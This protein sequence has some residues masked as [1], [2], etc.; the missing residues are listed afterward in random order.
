M[1]D[2]RTTQTQAGNVA[3]PGAP[4]GVPLLKFQAP[5]VSTYSNAFRAYGGPLDMTIEFGQI[6]PPPENLE[7]KS[8]VAITL[9]VET[10]K[11][12]LQHLANTLRQAEDA[13]TDDFLSKLS[14]KGQ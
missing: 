7:A 10:A 5:A 8:V 1:S 11:Q 13:R 3:A 14:V 9:N 12:L 6:A 2:E 4:G